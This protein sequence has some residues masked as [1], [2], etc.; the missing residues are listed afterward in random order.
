MRVIIEGVIKLAM[1]MSDRH[2]VFTKLRER[3]VND[4][5]YPADFGV[6]EVMFHIVFDELTDEQLDKIETACDNY[7]N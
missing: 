4:R 1:S 6:Y 7:Y 2:I 3:A 5:D